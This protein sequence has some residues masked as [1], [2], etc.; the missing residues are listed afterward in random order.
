[1]AAPEWEDFKEAAHTVVPSQL[2]L[3]D[4][5]KPA[6]HSVRD[7]KDWEAIHYQSWANLSGYTAVKKRVYRTVVLP[8]RRFYLSTAS[9]DNALAGAI[10]PP[11]GILFHGPPGCGKTVAA[12]YLASSLGLPMIRVR[13]ADVLHVLDPLGVAP[14]Q[15]SDVRAEV[16][17]IPQLDGRV[18]RACDEEAVVEEPM[19]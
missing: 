4:A 2:A 10:V 13:A 15:S 3:L 19:K 6:S 8:W 1:M 5:I 16:A 11:S 9:A 7:P 14:A 17:R 12:G 18:V